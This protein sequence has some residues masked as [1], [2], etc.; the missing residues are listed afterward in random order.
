MESRTI[1][2]GAGHAGGTA[3]ALLRQHG[4][5]GS[6]VLIGDEP[7]VPYHR[8]PLSKGFL[9]DVADRE[10]LKLRPDS[11]YV[12]NNI[13]LRL[14]DTA[15]TIDPEA[16]L[17]RLASGSEERYDT[18]I[19]ATG[20][21]NRQL[22]VAGSSLGGL[23]TLR[24]VAN[25]DDLKASFVAGGRIAIIGGGYIGLEVAASAVKQGMLPI[26]IEREERVLA[27]VASEQLSIFFEALHQSHNVEIRTG[28]S[29]R[30][31]VDDG[32]GFI[33]EV[34]LEDGSS[35]KCDAALIGVGANPCDG[36]AQSAGLECRGGV[37]VDHESRTSDQNIFA[38]GDMTLRPLP[39]YE[40]RMWRLESVPNALEQAKQA[41]S[42]I[43]GL[44]APASEVPWFWSDQYD[45]KLQIAGLP[46]DSDTVIERGDIQS[47]SF[48]VF[49][50]RGNVIRAVEAVNAPQEFMMGRRLIAAKTAVKAERLAERAI[51]MKD[52]AD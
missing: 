30:N 2:V 1:I 22:S 13:T 20:S 18:L 5:L 25:A 24:N 38:I 7:T 52:I 31:F 42:A 35:V 39:L 43:L 4:Y 33:C 6:V 23:H 9:S 40:N 11:F 37:V 28:S 15:Q 16:K 10:T 50:L 12:D 34:C 17:V 27:R 41:V 14:G 36:L 21:T 26:I 29:L 3:A 46:F 32:Q 49:H 8:P 51:P 48:A 19:L 44:P 47:S 45:V